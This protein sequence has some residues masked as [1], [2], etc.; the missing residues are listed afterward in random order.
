V[1]TCTSSAVVFCFDLD[2][3]GRVEGDLTSPSSRVHLFKV[4]Y[5]TLMVIV[6]SQNGRY[7]IA[8]RP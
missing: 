4:R 3:N 6:E 1:S 2:V 8:L 7:G 5:Y